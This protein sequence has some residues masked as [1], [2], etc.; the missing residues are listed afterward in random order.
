[1]FIREE[2]SIAEDYIDSTFRVPHCVLL[3]HLCLLC[4]KFG[5]RV[6]FPIVE[7]EKVCFWRLIKMAKYRTASVCILAFL[8]KL[9]VELPLSKKL[10]WWYCKRFI[11][12]CIF[13][14]D[15]WHCGRGDERRHFVIYVLLW[16]W[17][18][19]ISFPFFFCQLNSTAQVTVCILF[20][21]LQLKPLNMLDWSV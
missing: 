1:M 5:I 19:V 17:C 11:L 10:Q 20:F 18:Q 4:D 8:H 21:H 6:I 3:Y 2:F 12:F 16:M 9:Q 13:G 7:A 14:R 15:Q